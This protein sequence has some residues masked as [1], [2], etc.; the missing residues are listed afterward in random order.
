MW[1]WLRVSHEVIVMTQLGLWSHLKT[2][3]GLEI[4]FQV[5]CSHEYWQEA[6]VSLCRMVCVS[7]RTDSHNGNWFSPEQGF[8][9]RKRAMCFLI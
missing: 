9:E 6:L 8:G 2:F 5:F 1:F 4:H 7:Y 3:L